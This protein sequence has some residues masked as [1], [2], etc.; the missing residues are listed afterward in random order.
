L[1]ADKYAYFVNL[2]IPAEHTKY[3]DNYFDLGPGET[4]SVRISNAQVQ[5]TPDMLSIRSR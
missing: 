4:R 3:G 2:F 1:Q 5:L